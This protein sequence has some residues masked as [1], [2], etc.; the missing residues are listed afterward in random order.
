MQFKLPGLILI[1]TSLIIPLLWF[2]PIGKNNDFFPILSQ[3]L[4]AVALICMA[5]VQFIATRRPMI[6]TLFG[7]LDRCYVLHKWLGIAALAAVFLHDT[8]GAELSSLGD[9]SRLNELGEDL[10]EI[11][12]N[13]LIVLTLIT[14]LTK[15]PYHLWRWTHRLMGA[16][17]AVG[18]VHFLLTLK[19]FSNVDPLGLYITGFCVLGLICYF[20]TLLPLKYRHANNYSVIKTIKDGDCQ[21]VHL[22][23]VDSKNKLEFKAGQFAFYSFE[24]AGLHE[25]HPFTISKAP[26]DDALLR[27]TFKPLGDYTKRLALA[28]KPDTTVKV[29]GSYGH[30]T[31]KRNTNKREIWVAAGVGITPFAAWAQ[32]LTEQDA[33][34]QL[35]YTVKDRTMA[36]HIEE[37]EAV[38]TA[39]PNFSVSLIE[40]AKE[41]RLSAATITS[42]VGQ[43][44]SGT[45]LYYCGPRQL[46]DALLKDLPKFGLSKRHFHYE[47]FEI[48]SGIGLQRLITW[49]YRKVINRFF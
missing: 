14:V 9:G 41:K 45:K 21:V 19:P 20:Y 31:R 43:E 47:A 10:G 33:T 27:L 7:G 34:V 4:G 17:F 22:Q 46:R 36:T 12:L 39:L 8:I 3:Y 35:F 37:L 5:I 38:A 1:I 44:L 28:L 32:T 2:I 23:P 24:L 13:G 42:L 48:R 16:F 18:M 25:V 29:Y 26:T 40:T 49:V 11:G 6:E 15:I 30:F